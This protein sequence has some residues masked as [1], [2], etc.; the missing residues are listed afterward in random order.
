MSVSVTFHLMY[1][2]CFV[3]SRLLS[4]H[5]FLKAANSVDR[6]LEQYMKTGEDS[7]IQLLAVLLI[8]VVHS[9]SR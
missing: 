2:L 5:L 4:G 7:P 3:L 6:I 8:C 1:I 9:K